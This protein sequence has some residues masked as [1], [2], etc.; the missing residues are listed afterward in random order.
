MVEALGARRLAG[1]TSIYPLE[2][3]LPVGMATAAK[4]I[5]GGTSDDALETVQESFKLLVCYV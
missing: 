4:L 1:G 3:S 2:Y 5:Q